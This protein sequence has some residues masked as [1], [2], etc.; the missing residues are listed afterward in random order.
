MYFDL[1][2]PKT[3]ASSFNIT[4]V[5]LLDTASNNV[6]QDNTVVVP[7]DDTNSLAVE[8]NPSSSQIKSGDTLADIIDN[9]ILSNAIVG[10]TAD[11]VDEVIQFKLNRE[12]NFDEFNRLE[13]YA[14]HENLPFQ[15]RFKNANYELVHTATFYTS[16]PIFS[17]TDKIFRT[18]SNVSVYR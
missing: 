13:V 2:I 7:T 5:R 1:F 17:G 10:D 3:A 16:I 11:G 9:S 14:S 15:I 12:Y 6:L 8:T 18:K 4:E